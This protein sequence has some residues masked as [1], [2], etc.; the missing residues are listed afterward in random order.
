MGAV[1]QLAAALASTIVITASHVVISGGTVDER[2]AAR[3]EWKDSTY[4]Y[5]DPIVVVCVVFSW[6]GTVST[7][8]R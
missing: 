6:L 2:A 8:W 5:R 7:I 3:M 4:E 1:T